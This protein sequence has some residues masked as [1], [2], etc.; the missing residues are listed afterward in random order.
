MLIRPRTHRESRTRGDPFEFTF[1]PSTRGIG[2]ARRRFGAWLAAQRVPRLRL[3]DLLVVCSELCT[4]AVAC[5]NA[6]TGRIV[7]RA[8]VEDDRVLLAVEDD[9]PGFSWSPGRRLADVPESQEHGRGLLLVQ[10]LTDT[11]E[12]RRERGRTIVRCRG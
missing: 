8:H 5:A 12:V 1:P 2:V 10:A 11:L 7:V 6:R 3:D 9:G 4:N